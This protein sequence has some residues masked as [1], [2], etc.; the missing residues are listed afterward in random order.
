MKKNLLG[1]VA[2]AGMLFATSCAKEIGESA[3]TPSDGNAAVTFSI[4]LENAIATRAI[5]DGTGAKSLY[6]AAFNAAGEEVDSEQATLTG[7]DDKVTLTLVAG[8]EYTVAFWAQNSACDAYTV[9]WPNITVSYDGV[10]NNDE[11]RDAFFASVQITANESASRE[12]TLKRPFAQINFGVETSEGQTLPVAKSKMSL[13]GGNTTLDA[14]TGA[15]SGDAGTVTFDFN[16]VPAEKLVVTVQEQPKEYTYLSMSYL[17]VGAGSQ[18]T[19][20]DNVSFAFQNEGGETVGNT[21]YDLDNIPVQRNYRTN[22]LA[23][24]KTQDVEFTIVVDENYEGDDDKHDLPFKDGDEEDAASVTVSNISAEY[25]AETGN[26]TFSADFVY[27]GEGNVTA[28]FVCTPAATGYALT[29]AAE[30]VVTIPAEVGEGQ[31]TAEGKYDELGL[32]E[33]T[34][35]TVTV[36]VNIDGKPAEVT[37]GEESEEPQAP[38]LNIPA[39]S[40]PEPEYPS[41]TITSA[42]EL[43]EFKAKAK[44]PGFVKETVQDLTI[45]GS[46]ISE[47]DL[48]GLQNRVGTVLGTLTLTQIGQEDSELDTSEC[49]EYINILGSFVYKDIPATVYPNGTGR[50]TSLTG[51]VVI[52]NCP[53]FPSDWD[54]FKDLVEVGGSIKVTGPI[55]GFG[56]KFFPNVQ[57]VGGDFI[58]DGINDSFWDFK[59]ENLREI[60]GDLS[61]TNCR[62]FENL[63]GFDQLTKIGGNVVI[64]NNPNVPKT[65]D[66]AVGYCKIKEY[67]DSGVISP[68][69]TIK[70]G[71]DSNPVNVDELKSCNAE[72]EPEVPAKVTVS[73][74]MAECEGG[75]VTIMAGYEYTGEG[76]VKASFVCT[77]E[78]GEKVNIEATVE[79]NT[80][81]ATAKV[82]DLKLAPGKYT[83]T[84]E[85]TVDGGSVE[86]ELKGEA[87]TFTVPEPEP[88]VPADSKLQVN[89]NFSTCPSD[90]PEGNTSSIKDQVKTYMIDGQSFTFY[91]KDGFYW[92]KD[93]YILIGKATSYILLPAIEGKKLVTVNVKTT[94]SISTNVIA[95][96][97]SADGSEDFNLQTSALGAKADITW[98]IPVE[99]QSV[100]TAYRIQV[101]NAYNAQFAEINLVY[102]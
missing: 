66:W 41:Y 63:K 5:S 52:E 47:H 93:G 59:S 71:T 54:P 19:M 97:H 84:V 45:S 69:A 68:T 13:K 15:A 62:I 67:K 33:G 9:D 72:P 35:Y 80:L 26:V 42:S 57:K 17:L 81:E 49:F 3:V 25:S 78:A 10:L 50:I 56:Q 37:P 46:D 101:E 87:A 82:E 65:S 70:L 76:E 12:V 27:E 29:R 98:T 8:E 102:E 86:V 22:L 38:S 4:S 51:D 92:N 58:I 85:A 39:E 77:P 75:E 14:R 36:E 99:K 89:A 28:N 16:A 91:A 21:S 48:R 73:D 23:N 44:E 32:K 43:T 6:Y 96:I 94:G 90:F 34:D 20:L 64:Y 74:I 55:K 31:L 83:V 40:E 2:I 61:I 95:D 18:K 88:E 30:G 53:K 1:F 100:N 24:T 7:S 60:G 79:S 11:T